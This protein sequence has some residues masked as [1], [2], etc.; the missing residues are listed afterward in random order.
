MCVLVYVYKAVLYCISR[1][2]QVGLK[3]SDCISLNIDSAA[4]SV[5]IGI[6][7]QRL[8]FE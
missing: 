8:V 4:I 6:T 2:I 5:A 3:N 7:Y 1:Q